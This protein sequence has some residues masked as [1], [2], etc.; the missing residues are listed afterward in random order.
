MLTVATLACPLVILP[1]VHAVPKRPA[2]RVA[3]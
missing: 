2:P 3:P 1:A